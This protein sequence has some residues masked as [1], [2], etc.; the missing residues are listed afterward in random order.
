MSEI[1]RLDILI[2]GTTHHS[3]VMGLHVTHNGFDPF[4]MAWGQHEEEV[5]VAHIQ[6]TIDREQHAFFAF[7]RTTGNQKTPAYDQRSQRMRRVRLGSREQGP[8]DIGVASHLE[9]PAVH[10]QVLKATGSL[11]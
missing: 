2:L 9:T 5:R 1:N 7:M 11:F 10:T 6:P 4:Q 3:T 8:V